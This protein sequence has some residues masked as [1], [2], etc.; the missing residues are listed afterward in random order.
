MAAKLKF[1]LRPELYDAVW[2]NAEELRRPA[3]VLRHEHEQLLPPPSQGSDLWVLRAP[4]QVG[5]QALAA[6][7]IRH[8]SLLHV[9]A[10]LGTVL[11]H[12]R[13][14]R[15]FHEPVGGLYPEEPLAERLDLD[16]L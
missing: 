5:Q 15:G 6:Q 10:V 11:H 13:H 2:W 8:V 16:P 9:D 1:D 14:A 7:V 3:R 12:G 4:R